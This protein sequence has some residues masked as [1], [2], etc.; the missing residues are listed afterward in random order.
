M[1][2]MNIRGLLKELQS[3]VKKCQEQRR[4]EE[5]NLNHI[6]RTHAKIQKEEKSS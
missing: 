4:L 6:K 2:E 5:P 3:Y 1:K